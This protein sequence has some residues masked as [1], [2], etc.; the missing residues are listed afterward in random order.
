MDRTDINMAKH[1]LD[2]LRINDTDS[3]GDGDPCTQYHASLRIV[4]YTAYDSV[5][6]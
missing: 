4:H 2:L 5:K 1:I 3:I 6:L